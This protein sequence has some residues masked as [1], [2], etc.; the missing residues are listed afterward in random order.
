MIRSNFHTHTL[1][2][3]GKNSPRELVESAIELGFNALGFSG[4]SFTAFDTEY[5]MSPE[6]TEKYISEISALKEEYAGRLSIFCGIEQDIFSQIERERFDYVIGS[7]HYIKHRGK[8][9][10]VDLSAE[11][12]A[13]II[14]SYFSGDFISFA[15]AYFETVGEVCDVTGCD[16]IG[17]IDLIMK[18]ADILGFKQNNKYLEVAEKTVEALCKYNVPFEINTG[19]MARGVREEPYPSPELLGIIRYLG[20]S[21][22]INSDCH[23]KRYLGYGLDSAA[24]I[25]K[26]VGFEK[27]KILTANGF[28]DIKF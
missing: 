28:C 10:P 25:A 23:D 11:T 19:A 3:D 26:Q 20:G 22:I 9:L 18:Y 27:A 15:T 13:D 2:C 5:C 7:V 16:I 6:A 12:T 24:E 8:Y 21:I 1:F 14:R 4:H 17:H